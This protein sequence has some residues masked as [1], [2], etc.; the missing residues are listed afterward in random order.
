MN[1]SNIRMTAQ[2]FDPVSQS[3]IRVGSKHGNKS[4]HA[5]VS[6]ELTRELSK[7]SPAAL[8]ITSI[9]YQRAEIFRGAE[10]SQ[11]Y[12]ALIL[13]DVISVG[14]GGV[15]TQRLTAPIR[16]RSSFPQVNGSSLSLVDKAFQ[17]VN[18]SVLNTPGSYM[19]GD[20]RFKTEMK[21]VYWNGEKS[22]WLTDGCRTVVKSDDGGGEDG[23]TSVTCECY[24][25][26]HFSVILVS[27]STLLLLG[28]FN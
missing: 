21:C 24:H 1:L 23:S 18:E 8:N 6:A 5:E 20:T 9:S 11:K 25:M 27:C 15:D 26:T 14:V 28:L 3:N 22:R 12:P 7:S 13:S 19:V 16:V 2:Q 10:M 17:D 4:T